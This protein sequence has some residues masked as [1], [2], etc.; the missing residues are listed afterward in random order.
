MRGSAQQVIN[1]NISISS[2]AR[3]QKQVWGD[4]MHKA[5]VARLAG[6]AALLAAGSAAADTLTA[7]SFTIADGAADFS[8]D[9]A[10]FSLSGDFR[11]SLGAITGESDA[12]WLSRVRGGYD[13]HSDGE[14]RFW[15][16]TLQPLMQSDRN[17]V[18][19][20]ARLSH[21]QD[22]QTLNAGLG[23]RWL[24]SDAKL[25]LGANAFYD[26]SFE[27]G[28]QRASLGLEAIGPVFSLRGN[29][30]DAV[31]GWQDLGGGV[32]E[33][34]L[35]GAD[36]S[37]D[38]QA[39]HMPWL[40][41]GARYFQWNGIEADDA[42]GLQGTLTADVSDR[43]QF[44]GTYAGSDDPEGDYYLGVRFRLAG[45]DRPTATR[46]FW[47]PEIIEGRDLSAHRLDFVERENRIITESQGGAFAS[48]TITVSR[49]D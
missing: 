8:A 32:R 30:Y 23:Y 47:S 26:F 41:I 12:D 21:A 29:F 42:T 37:L 18:F 7:P 1:L 25:L 11:R 36:L 45:G 15:V 44:V 38:S 22:D 24:S 16:E 6:A 2:P 14:S 46:Q 33:H 4:Y 13:Y 35:G 49:G 10:G 9:G 48:G 17:T 20:Q 3:L 5:N 31:S 39:P 27:A 40:R 43:V 19:W 28:H 34:A